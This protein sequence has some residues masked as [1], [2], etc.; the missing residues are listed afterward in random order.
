MMNSQLTQTQYDLDVDK[1]LI[2]RGHFRYTDQDNQRTV[3]E[4]IQLSHNHLPQAKRNTF[5]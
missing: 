4:L 1:G 5:V 3:V 2:P